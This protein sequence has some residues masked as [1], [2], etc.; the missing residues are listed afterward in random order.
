MWCVIE[1]GGNLCALLTY[2][3]VL[4]VQVGFIR[5]GIWEELLDGSYPAFA[6]LIVFQ[7]HCAMIF[8]SHFKCMTTEP[9]ILPKDC[10]KIL[11]KKLAPELQKALKMIQLELVNK[12]SEQNVI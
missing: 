10:D 12:E 4:V 7:Y 1:L 8:W 5:I 3:I 6:H 11:F 9:G 2:V